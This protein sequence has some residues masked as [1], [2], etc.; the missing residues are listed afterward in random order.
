MEKIDKQLIVRKD[1]YQLLISYLKGSRG[2]TPMDR[3]NAEDLQAE[4]QK[5]R[6]V[7]K[8]DF[9][10]DV[11]GINSTVLLKTEE[12]DQLIKLQ[13][14]TPDKADIKQKRV[15]VI[16][17]I[18][19]ALIGFRQGEKVKWLVPGGKKTFTILAVLNEQPRELF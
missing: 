11:V 8:A 4:L 16:A 18:G 10:D 1:D 15:S 19:I 7:E 3:R 5:A 9:P 17:P 6:L 12:N 2:R 14:V 13:L